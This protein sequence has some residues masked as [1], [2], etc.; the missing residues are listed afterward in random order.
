MSS[1]KPLARRNLDGD[2]SGNERV[3]RACF[4]RRFSHVEL[5]IESETLKDLDPERMKDW[6]K[7]WAKQVVRNAAN[8]CKEI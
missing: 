2:N 5:K 7:I 6:I 4:N 3:K 1:E 8:V